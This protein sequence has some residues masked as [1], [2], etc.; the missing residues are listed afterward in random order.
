MTAQYGW[1]GKECLNTATKILYPC[2]GNRI[3]QSVLQSCQPTQVFRTIIAPVCVNVVY[4]VLVC[5]WIAKECKSDNPMNSLP[6]YFHVASLIV[7][8]TKSPDIII[9]SNTLPLPWM[10]HH[11]PIVTSRIMLVLIG[12]VFYLVVIVDTY[13]K[14]Y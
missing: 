3:V 2:T 8:L 14:Q 10:P 13:H 1:I 11:S 7:G 12:A 4:H 6:C 5:R 9:L